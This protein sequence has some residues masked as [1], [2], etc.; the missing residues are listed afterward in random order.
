[1][2]DGSRSGESSMKVG[3]LV[4]YK[5]SAS[6]YK[7]RIGAIVKTWPGAGCRSA[8]IYFPGAEGQGRDQA[9]LGQMKNG[10]HA[11][12]FDELEVIE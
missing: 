1:M 12:G 8:Y 4:K 3:D 6:F 10:L 9:G 7:G 5:G 11:M 2:G